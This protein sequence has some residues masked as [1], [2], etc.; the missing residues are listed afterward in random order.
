[1]TAE[2]KGLSA[3]E[4]PAAM[5]ELRD[6]LLR[7]RP[8]LREQWDASASKRAIAIA[9]V[10]MRKQAGRSQTQLAERAGWDK[11]FVSRLEGAGGAVPDSATLMRYAAAC[12]RAV[13][14]VFASV[15]PHHA[16]VIDAV[17]LAAPAAGH[18]FESLRGE[19]FALH[20]AAAE[21]E[22]PF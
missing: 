7:G 5:A 8:G 4:Q 18:P 16:H 1:M 20:A 22:V 15:A 2:T 17:T 9:L 10:R 3:G 6:E 21:D 12:D 13:G 14:L 19:E 11:A